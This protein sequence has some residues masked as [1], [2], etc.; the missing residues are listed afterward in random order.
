MSGVL[1]CSGMCV[2][3]VRGNC[4]LVKVFSSYVPLLAILAEAFDSEYL[5]GIL[6]ILRLC[7]C[8]WNASLLW[9]V[10]RAVCNQRAIT[11][12]DGGGLRSP[13]QNFMAL[14]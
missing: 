3:P 8:E 2:V 14:R 11:F 10:R 13:D 1:F 9:W 12:C 7:C 5:I 6:G 4:W